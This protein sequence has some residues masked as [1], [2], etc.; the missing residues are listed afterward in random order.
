MSQTGIR[1]AAHQRLDAMLATVS[2][3]DAALVVGGDLTVLVAEVRSE[4]RVR[5]GLKSGFGLR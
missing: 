5:E 3:G 4:I 1:T 2:D